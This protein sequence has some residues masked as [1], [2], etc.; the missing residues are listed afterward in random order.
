ATR[1]LIPRH[2]WFRPRCQTATRAHSRSLSINQLGTRRAHNDYGGG[3]DLVGDGITARPPGRMSACA[4]LGG[5]ALRFGRFQLSLAVALL[6][7]LV[8]GLRALGGG[9]GLG[10]GGVA[11]RLRFRLGV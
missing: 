2:S 5:L 8:L 3:K 7:D 1:R 10:L 4:L 11:K 9:L 6:G